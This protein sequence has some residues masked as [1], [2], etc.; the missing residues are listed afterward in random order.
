MGTRRFIYAK[1]FL[2]YC[3]SGSNSGAGRSTIWMPAS[4]PAAFVQRS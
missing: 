2:T 4:I 3:A 1:F